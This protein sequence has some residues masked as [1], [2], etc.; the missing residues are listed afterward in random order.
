MLSDFMKF[1]KKIHLSAG[2]RI[3]IMTFGWLIFITWF[4]V[5]L[6]F[7]KSDIKTVKMGYMPVITNMAAPLLDFVSRDSRDIRFSAI[8]FASFAEMAESLRND[9]IDAAFMIAPLAVVLKQQREDVKI[10]YIGN[11][12]ESTLVV[13]KN[14]GI[15]RFAD[16]SGKTL[17]VPMRYSGHN[18]S[19]LDLME[20]YGL[21]G[22]IHIVE[23]N[24]PDMAAA[25]SA[26]ALDAYYVGEPFAA[27]AL[28]S[29]DARLLFYV[30]DVWENF[31]CNLVLVKNDLIKNDPEL[32]GNLVQSAARSGFWARKHPDSAARIASK[33]WNQSPELVLHAMTVPKDRILYDR[34]IPVQ[35]EIEHLAAKMLHHGLIENDD[36]RGLVDDRF[37]KQADISNIGD[38]NTILNFDW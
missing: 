23:M 19:S 26:K 14:S 1:I 37:A 2:M 30:E 5:W 4:H 24:P 29:G 35:A 36:I 28:K 11:R 38:I 7:D 17:A 8:K 15:H 20:K 34:Y 13:A 9:D 18:I 21:E 31:I 16:L 33:Y 25:M 12:H 10:I 22:R 27:Q 3:G 6:N 32:V